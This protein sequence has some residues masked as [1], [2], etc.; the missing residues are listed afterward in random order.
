MET[1][2]SLRAID[3]ASTQPAKTVEVRARIPVQLRDQL[4]QLA[5]RSSWIE[6][7]SRGNDAAPLIVG[8]LVLLAAARRAQVL[9]SQG[10]GP[11]QAWLSY[12]GRHE[13]ERSVE[14]QEPSGTG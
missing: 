3:S 5:S 10:Y 13:G 11:L 9:I 4:E 12:S 14:A 1:S 2:Q 7:H 6:Q 8:A